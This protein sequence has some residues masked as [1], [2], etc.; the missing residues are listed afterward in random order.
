[1]PCYAGTRFPCGKCGGCLAKRASDW[2]VRLLHEK[3]LHERSSFITLT[4]ADD[5]VVDVDKVTCQNFL[6]RLRK[7]LAPSRIRFYLASEYGDQSHRPHYHA[8][9]FGHDFTLDHGAKVVRSGLYTSP[10]L[11]AAWGLGHVSAGEVSGASIRYVCNYILGKEDV[12]S[13]VS[14]ETG[15]SRP[16]APTFA[17]MSRN[18]GIG[19]RW[20]DAH[21]GE[22]YRDDDVVCGSF[23]RRPPRYYDM[24]TFKED[25]SSYNA[26]RSARRNAN[27]KSMSRSPKSWL[28]NHDPLRRVAAG[29]IHAS[30]SAMRSGEL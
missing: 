30:K 20:I 23:R 27:V 1:M 2:S 6:K 8:I 4:Y 5:E 12:P 14:L 7:S 26:L 28:Q 16:L 21:S 18:P 17:L 9:I 11:E 15:D 24:R 10:L 29:K 25:E 13:V 22:T 3:I 19:A